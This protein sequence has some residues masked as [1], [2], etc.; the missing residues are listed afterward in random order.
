MTK[1]ILVTNDDGVLAPGLLALAQEMKKYGDVTILAPDRN[2]SGGGHV[3]TLDRALRVRE[4]RLGRW[5]TSLRQRRRSQCCVSLAL[6]GYFKEKFDLVVSGI[7]VGRESRSRCDLLWHRHRRHG[8]GDCRGSRCCSFTRNSRRDIS[9]LITPHPRMQHALLLE[10]VLAH[11][12]PEETLLNVNIP[13]LKKEELKGFPRHPS[14]I[15]RVSQP[16]RRTHRPAQP[17]I[18]LDRRRR[19]HW[20][21]RIWHRCR[22]TLRRLH[23]RHT[24]A[25]RP[26]SLSRS[27]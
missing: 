22:C 5:L 24:A 10:N 20:R 19:P 26:H 1:Q 11:G 9:K 25:T 21:P 14:G 13:F 6:L 18:L 8:S 15:A 23:L 12:L 4:F 7:N 17:P 2:W 27:I 16:P 3:K